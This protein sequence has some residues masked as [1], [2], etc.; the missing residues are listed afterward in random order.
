MIYRILVVLLLNVFLSFMHFVLVEFTRR[1]TKVVARELTRAAMYMAN[2]QV[3]ELINLY[4]VKIN[5]FEK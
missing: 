3:L 4:Q 2:S 1:Q 5:I